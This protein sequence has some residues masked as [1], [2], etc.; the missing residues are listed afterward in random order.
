LI[1]LGWRRVI[2][3]AAVFVIGDDDQHVAPLRTLLQLADDLGDMGIARSDI[4]ITGML[5]E[6]ALRFVKR[7]RRQ[8]PG[9]CILQE[10]AVEI[11]QMPGPVSGMLDRI[12][13][14]KV[15][16]RLMMK[17]EIRC[18]RR[19]FAIPLSTVQGGIPGTG[20]P[21]PVDAFGRQQIADIFLRLRRQ[22]RR[23]GAVGKQFGA[24]AGS[25]RDIARLIGRLHGIDRIE[26]ALGIGRRQGAVIGI[27]R[28]ALEH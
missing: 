22:G 1:G 17:L 6:V 12:H 3:E 9:G 24:V 13:V 18:R 10:T 26:H 16:E 21:G 11:L 8:F 2:P 5:I 25:R 20:I 19:K 7:H 28:R 23:I 15:I 27:F 14:G 4:G